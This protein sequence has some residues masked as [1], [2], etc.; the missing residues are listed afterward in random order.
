MNAYLAVTEADWYGFLSRQE[1]V[2]R[3]E[4]RGN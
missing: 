2:E 1:D 3:A 4:E